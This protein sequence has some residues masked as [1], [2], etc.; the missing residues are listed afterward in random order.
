MRI[1]V[2][3]NYHSPLYVVRPEAEIFIGLAQLGVEVDVMSFPEA[4]YKTRFEEFG[5]RYIGHH[6][7]KKWEKESIEIIKKE[8]TARQYDIV[9]AFNNKA[10]TCAIR[11]LKNSKTK[12]VTYR[13]VTGYSHWYDPTSYL[14][15][16]HPRVDAITCVAQAATNYLKKQL[17]NKDKVFTVYKGHSPEWYEK[18]KVI[19]LSN[20]NELKNV[21]NL[22]MPVGICVA[23]VRK[24]KGV[25]YLL[26]ATALLEVKDYFNLLLIGNGMDHPKYLK[27]IAQSGMS[28]YIHIL[29]Y[30]D[31]VLSWIKTSDFLIL[32]SIKGEGLPK[33]VIE[34]MMQEVVPIATNVGGAPELIESGK[35]GFI[36]EK[37]SPKALANAI[38]KLLDKDMDTKNMGQN[39]K[40]HII[41]KFNTQKSVTDMHDVYKSILEM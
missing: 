22:E 28:K 10:I 21:I 5:I 36:V 34:A 18:I 19:D 15:H 8:N 29:G 25:K 12:L 30:K 6:P 37:K 39:A 26:E 13:G 3:S 27:L 11:A 4:A 31:D 38:L 16:L 17:W 1:L 32:P 7:K 2:I 41:E 14:T 40:M 35:S 23:N 20:T 33:V 24:M 9:H